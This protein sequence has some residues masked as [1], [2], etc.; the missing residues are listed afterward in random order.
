[1]A[2]PSQGRDHPGAGAPLPLPSHPY[3]P[4]RSLGPRYWLLDYRSEGPLG[5]GPELAVRTDGGDAVGF[6][7]YRAAV[8]F[9]L[10]RR[11]VEPS[12]ELSWRVRRAQVPWSLWL[13]HRVEARGGLSVGGRR[14]R[15]LA[16]AAGGE[17][18]ADYAVP[19]AGTFGA[20]RLAGGLAVEYLARA[21][22]FGGRLD[23][24]EPPPRLPTLGW[25]TRL[26]AAWSFADVTRQAWD[27]TS[28]EG[29]RLALSAAWREPLLGGRR[30]SLALRW[31]AAGYLRA[32][33]HRLHVLAVRYGGGAGLAWDD[34]PPPRF[35]LGGFGE[36]PLLDV[37]LG[38][39]PLG[40]VALR[41]YE[42]WAR[43]G[44]W[45]GLLQTEWRFPLLRPMLGWRTLPLFL[46]RVWGT[47]FVDVGEAAD[48]LPE[49]DDWGLGLGA[50]LHADVLLGYYLPLSLRAGL[51][52]GVLGE[53]GGTSFYVHVGQ[54]F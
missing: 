38:A 49:R 11:P 47:L 34:G 10:R 18:S 7:A 41:G 25:G 30:R 54:A 24:N 4:L 32:P 17:L 19:A 13:Y 15:W 46:R 23:P 5:L 37:V 35:G 53:G 50:E 26:R 6:H 33:W 27:V 42:P 2:P 39:P 45:F 40:G 21:A 8:R 31:A 3:E 52:W 20:H 51:A 43:S 44:A 29:Y 22:P 48:G 9:A 16:R 36:R 28:S 1:M 12:A 14:R